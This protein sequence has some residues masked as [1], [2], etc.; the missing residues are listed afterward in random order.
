MLVDDTKL[1]FVAAD[2]SLVG[3]VV[4]IE[5]NHLAIHGVCLKNVRQHDAVV[6]VITAQI[7]GT[8]R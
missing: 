2:K 5:S 4:A 3:V 7:A 8:W 6:S 1:N